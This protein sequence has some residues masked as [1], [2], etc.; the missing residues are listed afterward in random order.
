MFVTIVQFRKQI[1]NAFLVYKTYVC[2]YSLFGSSLSGFSMHSWAAHVGISLDQVW[3][4][5]QD[6]TSFSPTIL[7]PTL[8]ENSAME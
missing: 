6:N 4:S 3:S 7:K 5:K 1:K 8:H 2:R